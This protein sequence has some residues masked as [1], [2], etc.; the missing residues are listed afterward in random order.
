MPKGNGYGEGTFI[1]SRL[2]LSPAFISLG[3]RDTAPVV[4]SCSAP[5]LVLFLGKRQYGKRKDK[6]GQKVRVRVDGNRF[7]LTYKE[8]ES[9]GIS[10]KRATRAIDEL[11]AKG[12]ISIIDPGGL[13]EM[14]KAVYALEEDY[15][16]WRRGDDPIRTRGRDA[17][18][19]FCGKKINIADVNGGHPH[20][21]QRR[22]PC[23]KTRT[24]AGDTLKRGKMADVHE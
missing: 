8:L 21:R 18:R 12:F 11:L 7:T 10:Q 23:N 15:R 4:S 2:F 6:K 13:Y 5:V 1:E 17:R 24:S 20:G 19:G 9:R 22:T 14:H 16:N 3:Q